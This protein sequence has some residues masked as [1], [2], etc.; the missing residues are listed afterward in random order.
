MNFTYESLK[1]G[2]KVKMRNFVK[3]LRNFVVTYLQFLPLCWTKWRV[4][5]EL[6]RLHSVLFRELDRTCRLLPLFR[7]SVFCRVD[8]NSTLSLSLSLSAHTLMQH[9]FHH[10]RR[11]QLS[12]FSLPSRIRLL[13]S[14]LFHL[15]FRYYAFISFFFGLFQSTKCQGLR[16]YTNFKYSM[17][18]IAFNHRL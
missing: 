6:W 15:Q 1:E 11:T 10:F 4:M 8:T 14:L 17:F 12:R 9:G 3:S 2:L 18:S 13:H 5:Y 7:T 16:F